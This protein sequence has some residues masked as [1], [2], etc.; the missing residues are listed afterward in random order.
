MALPSNQL[1]ADDSLRFQMACTFRDAK[2]DGGLEDCMHVTDTVVPQA[3]HLALFMVHGSSHF[4]PDVRQRDPACRLLDSKARFRADK[5][6]TETIQMLPE[7][8]EL[9]FLAQRFTQIADIGRLPAGHAAV[10]PA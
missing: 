6:V 3:A 2:Q 5:Y 4:L 9:V 7:K 10:A 8:P 1:K